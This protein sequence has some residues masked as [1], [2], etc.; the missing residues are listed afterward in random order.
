ME[1]IEFTRQEL[2]DMVWSEPMSRLAKKYNISDNE[3]RKI[4]EKNNIHV[5]YIGYWQK[6]QYGKRIV[7]T[8]LPAAG[9]GEDKIILSHRDKDGKYV[10]KVL[11]PILKL[12]Q[13]IENS[14]NLPLK[15]PA[16][17]TNPDKL[18]TQARTT[19]IHKKRE[20]Y[21]YQGV[22]QTYGEELNIKVTPEN[23]P[24]ALRFFDTI[25]KLLRARNHDVILKSHETYAMINGEEIQII[26]RERMKMVKK[27]NNHSWNT[28]DYHPSGKLAFVCKG[29]HSYDQKEFL[30]GT[31]LIEE[32]LSHILAWLELKAEKKKQY[33]LELE[34]IWR[35]QREERE[36]EE[37]LIQRKE[38][39]LEDF[40]N[41][42]GNA[43]QWQQAKI[44]REYIAAVEQNSD[45][46]IDEELRGWINWAKKKAD[47]Y[48]PLIKAEDEL[49]G[50][51]DR[52]KIG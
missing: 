11:S 1:R 31:M 6:I 4:C 47:W 16:R 12:K 17:L 5:P 30:D 51:G 13:E 9:E 41:L 14:P 45:S 7:K 52:L 21:H 26:L 3:I 40:K 39:E 43:H 49:L 42:I 38:K 29:E 2:Y 33:R 22:V 46:G 37:E 15:V 28:Y 8:K 20:S 25:I 50:E 19:L 35:I 36:K 27:E 10:E 23:I 32:R 34:E 24:R 48:D 18:I 44:L